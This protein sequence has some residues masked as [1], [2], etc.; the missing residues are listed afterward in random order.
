LTQLAKE[1]RHGITQAIQQYLTNSDLIKARDA[2]GDVGT[3][4]STSA[5]SYRPSIRAVLQ[6]NAQRLQEAL[7]GLEEYGKVQSPEFGSAIEKLRYRAYTLQRALV[8]GQSARERLRHAQLYLLVSKGSCAASIEWTIREAVAGGVS[9]VQLREKDKTDRQ[10]LEIANDVRQ[11]T[12]EVSALFIM[13]DR[14][15]L[16]ALVQ[17]DGVHLGQDDLPIH[18]ARKIIGPDRLIGI[19]THEP[20]QLEQAILAGA[21]YVGAGPTFGSKTKTFEVLA[22]P[23]YLRHVHATTS[24]PAFAIGGIGPDNIHLVVEAGLRRVAVGHAI[25]QAEEPQ[26]IARQMLSAL[27]DKPDSEHETRT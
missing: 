12:R 9:I 18:E 20:K 1:L 16:A 19:S 23:A 3:E 8:V 17:A 22:G 21:D 6:A 5:E 14:P 26:A 11:V 4:I 13:N 10:L 27:Q 25:C 2:E 15:D 24:L 7:R